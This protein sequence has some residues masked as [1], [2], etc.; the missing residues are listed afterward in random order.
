MEIN[1]I[2]EDHD[3]ANHMMHTYLVIGHANDGNGIGIDP[4]IILGKFHTFLLKILAAIAK[5]L[6]FLFPFCN[7]IL[8]SPRKVGV[9][10]LVS[11]YRLLRTFK[12]DRD[13]L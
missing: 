10:T 13:A 5:L 2:T 4:N 9:F 3:Q 8:Q 12:L 1:I 7:G 6:P 11:V